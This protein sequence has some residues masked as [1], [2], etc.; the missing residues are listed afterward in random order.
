MAH[1][2]VRC[3]TPPWAVRVGELPK[4]RQ[5]P[6]VA[7]CGTALKSACPD[8]H[9]LARAEQRPRLRP[10]VCTPSARRQ[11]MVGT[12]S[13][14]GQHTVGAWSAHGQTPTR[15]LHQPSGQVGKGRAWGG[16][17][18]GCRCACWRVRAGPCPG[19]PHPAHA[20]VLFNRPV[21]CRGKR[22]WRVGVH[23]GC[24]G[25]RSRATHVGSPPPSGS[26]SC[27][28]GTW[29]FLASANRW[30]ARHFKWHRCQ[31]NG[32]TVPPVPVDRDT[33]V[34][35]VCRVCHCMRARGEGTRIEAVS[36]N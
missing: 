2:H 16:A 11:H 13:A 23:L 8:A 3:V 1:L 7:F 17:R 6:T 18:G 14:Y 19:T 10:A 20:H 26:S 12:R 31:S 21:R 5:L 35:R 29:Q 9:G 32:R 4:S 27:N 22:E 28:R 30:A 36:G 33:T 34:C 24:G 25:P 15:R